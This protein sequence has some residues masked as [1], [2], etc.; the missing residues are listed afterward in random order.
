MKS[1][2]D[3]VQFCETAYKRNDQYILGAFGNR[4]TES[5]INQKC[6][7]YSYNADN[8]AI[9]MTHIGKVAHDCYGLLKAFV[10]DNQNGEGHYAINGC[11]DR[12]EYMA[13]AKA[14]SKGSIATIPRKKGV[15]VYKNGHVGFVVDCSAPSYQDWIVIEV[16]SIPAGMYRRTL[17]EGGWTDWFKDTYLE[18]RATPIETEGAMTHTIARGDTLWGLARTYVT[19]VAE[20]Q[21]L[22]PGIDANNLHVGQVVVIRED[23]NT[24]LRVE[25]VRLQTELVAAQQ[26]IATAKQERDRARAAASAAISTL[27]DGIK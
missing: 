27:E 21:R 16:Y 17:K 12:N 20:I 2:L 13:F 14:T 10:W 24:A 4:I 7:Q 26:Q 25:V 19:T 3:F 9:L 18:Y 11:A 23:G 6:N 1:N 15:V 8:R 22:N 5:F